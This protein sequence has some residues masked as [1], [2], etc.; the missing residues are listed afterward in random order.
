MT[1]RNDVELANT[2]DKLRILEESYEETVNDPTEDEHVRELTMF[3]LKRIINQL[4]EEIVRYEC[5]QPA[6]Q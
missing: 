5:R 6:K 1:L 3:S 2:R 4:K